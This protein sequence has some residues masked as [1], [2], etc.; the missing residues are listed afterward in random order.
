MGGMNQYSSWLGKGCVSQLCLPE[1][2]PRTERLTQ[3]TLIFSQSWRLD[4][5]DRG[6][7]RIISSEAS[8][9]GL[10]IAT[11]SLP[12]YSLSLCAGVPLLSPCVS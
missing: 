4:V 12:L 5:R 2:M 7:N 8:L 11:L 6:A 1:Q 10:R 3:H 9:L